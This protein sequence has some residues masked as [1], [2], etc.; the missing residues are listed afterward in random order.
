MFRAERITKTILEKYPSAVVNIVDRTKE[1]A[2]H[3][4]M[5]NIDDPQETHLDINVCDS[6]FEGCSPLSAI[7][8]INRLI[9]DEFTKGLH[10][11]SITCTS[12]NTK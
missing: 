2:G 4:E 1:H 8:E 11:V 3:R 10:A 7:R 9:K 5:I 12:P 6:S